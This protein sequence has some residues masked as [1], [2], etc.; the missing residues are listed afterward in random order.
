MTKLEAFALGAGLGALVFPAALEVTNRLLG[1]STLDPTH[2]Q[3]KA[4]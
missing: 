1:R 2:T 3:E 4:S